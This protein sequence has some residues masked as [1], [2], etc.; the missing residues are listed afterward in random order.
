MYPN[1]V[2]G[3]TTRI[4][5]QGLALA[6]IWLTLNVGVSIAGGAE[7]HSIVSPRDPQSGLPTGST[8][9]SG[10]PSSGNTTTP[11]P[12]NSTAN[13]GGTAPNAGGVGNPPD[14]H[15]YIGTVTLVK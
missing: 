9:N 4:S 3:I 12:S 7:S 14:K 10:K 15:S 13:K 6:V 5:V 8:A 1:N 2:R 11:T